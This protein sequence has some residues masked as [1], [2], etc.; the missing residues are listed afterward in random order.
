MEEHKLPRFSPGDFGRTV[1]TPPKTWLLESILVTLF[2]CM[3]LGL[4]G[5]VHAAKADAYYTAGDIERAK[6]ASYDAKVWTTAAFVTGLIIAVIYVIGMLISL[7]VE[8]DGSF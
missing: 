2:C 8:A 6:R 1:D 5:I 4:V 7:S 3:P